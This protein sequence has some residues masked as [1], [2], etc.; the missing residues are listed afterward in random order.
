M[1]F[2]EE[3]I[4]MF[5]PE[6]LPAEQLPPESRLVPHSKATDLAFYTSRLRSPEEVQTAFNQVYDDLTTSG[7]S[8]ALNNAQNAWVEEQDVENKVII[9]SLIED[10]TISKRDKIALLNQ[11]S[12]GYINPDLKQKYAM[13]LAS[14]DNSQG[15]LEQ[16]AQEFQVN[17]LQP[18]LQQ[19]EVVRQEEDDNDWF[20]DTLGEVI[21]VINL[22]PQV[23]AGTGDF[24]T[25]AVQAVRMYKQNGEVDWEELAKTT[26][27][28]EEGAL[29]TLNT[30]SIEPIA[31]M[32]GLDDDL[33]ESYVTAGLGKVGEGFE[34]LAEKIA[35]KKIL[36]IDSKEQAM[37]A[38]EVLGIAVPAGFATKSALKGMKHKAGGGADTS[39]KA[40]PK[41]GGDV[42]TEALTEKNGN[43]KAKELNTEKENIVAENVLPDA[44]D[45]APVTGLKVDINNRLSK[46]VDDTN[47]NDRLLFETTFDD[48]IVKREARIQDVERRKAIAEEAGLTQNLASS[49]Y[50]MYGTR[51]EGKMVF[52]QT[53]DYPF[54]T[55]RA[56]LETANKLKEIADD[57]ATREVSIDLERGITLKDKPLKQKNTV[58]I[59]DIKSNEIFTIDEFKKT[60]FDNRQFQV[61]L[62]YRKNY[63]LLAD[64]M[65]GEAFTDIEVPSLLGKKIGTYL[66]RTRLGEYLFG[67]GFTAQWFEKARAA[68]SPKAGRIRKDIVREFNYLTDQNKHLRNETAQLIDMHSKYKADH[69]SK[70]RLRKAFRHLDTADIDKLDQ[71]QQSWRKAQNELYEITNQGEKQ[72]LV[73]NGY[74]KGVFIDGEYKGA[75]K[76]VSKDDLTGY[77]MKTLRVYDPKLDEFVEF[78]H[79]KNR[80]DG[81]YSEDGRK[82]VKLDSRDRN[83]IRKDKEVGESSDFMLVKDAEIDIL[84]TRVLPKMKGYA[85]REYKSNFFIEVRPKEGTIIHNGKKL[86]GAALDDFIETKGT[87]RTAYEAELLTKQLQKDL[88]DKF[89]VLTP[90]SAKLDNIRDYTA[91]YRLH[92]DQ[93]QNALA[94]SDDMKTVNGDIRSLYD[95]VLV[96]PKEALNRAA[97]RIVR[98]GSYEQFDMAFTKKFEQDFKP[99]LRDGRFPQSEADISAAG[100]PPMP[101]KDLAKM[102]AEAKAL[103]NRQRHFQNNVV[104]KGDAVFQ[105]LMHSVADIFEKVKIGD[106]QLLRGASLGARKVGDVGY[107]GVMNQGKRLA[108]LMYITFQ[109]PMRHLIIQPMMFLEQS[110]IFPKTFRSTMT[111]TPVHVVNLL[112]EGNPL[113][114]ADAPKMIKMLPEKYRAEFMDELKAMRSQ[115]ILE[116]IDQNLAMQ[117][118]LK[119]HSKQLKP[120]PGF[121]GGI[122]DKLASKYKTA[123]TIFN[124]MGFSAGE[125]TN[126]V[127][128]WL[129]N[130]ERWK[131]NPKN[132]GKDWRDPRALEEISFEAWKQSGAMTSAGAYAFQRTGVLSFLTQFQSINMKGFMNILQDNATNLTRMDR[133]KL[134]ANRIAM[135]GVEYGAPLAGGKYLIDYLMSSDDPQVVEYAEEMRRGYLDRFFN[136]MT[137]SITGEESDVTISQSASLGATNAYADIGESLLNIGRFISGDPDARAPN[138]PSVQAL[139]R[140]WEKAQKATHLFRYQPVTAD[141]LKDSL[142]TLTEVTSFGSNTMKM[143]SML[144]Y[145]DI[146]TNYGKSKGIAPKVSDAVWQSLGMKTRA[147]ADQW[148]QKE[149]MRNVD[150]RIKE[151]SQDMTTI[152]SNIMSKDPD[153]ADKF[154]GTLNQL[155]SILEQSETFS[156]SEMD[157]IVERVVKEDANR[158]KNNETDTIIGWIQ[159]TDS[160]SPDVQKIISLFGSHPDPVVRELVDIL[161]GKPLKPI[162][163]ENE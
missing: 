93:Y 84:P 59:R 29:K 154:F 108:S 49:R 107:T 163:E 6:D 33:Q 5:T 4:S 36:G 2:E 147:E 87:A 138:I 143:L 95:D 60:K 88:G 57:L 11:Y 10:E 121:L 86:T 26:E 96:D 119:G 68:L 130:K 155:I 159:K 104:N 67:T 149:L 99:V 71:I 150:E 39:L 98:T 83:R 133:A 102:E 19:S 17:E 35:E 117:E 12:S 21:S 110:I 146:V 75:V 85:Q 51:L 80:T 24:L 82:I 40:N 134:V 112:S 115:G 123:E 118:V 52:S 137:S 124:K 90:R 128:L 56:T 38:L 55:K 109:M 148:R 46:V 7:M 25:R 1:A 114:R 100:K 120:T 94:R 157:R 145:E 20:Q 162:D 58:M 50:N 156:P 62:N 92:N 122:S 13:Q 30:L 127:G 105:N 125:L 111:K 54:T 27:N 72:R 41:A 32:L 161:K 23:I 44:D 76:S 42:V 53:T 70:V 126:R 129:Q 139:S 144:A 48:N 135:H 103:F 77:D 74:G 160:K 63:D 16:E 79:N 3:N 153:N 64:E 140:V 101:G 81:F 78:K 28:L 136:I 65:L 31:K 141:S 91:E 61:E 142:A 37:F 69:V 18:V 43:K 89:E 113:V 15:P 34:W 152:I 14:I 158:Y 97:N 66:N 131:A 47:M 9:S 22:V 116:S 106:K 8:T 132:K 45:G 73:K 151:A